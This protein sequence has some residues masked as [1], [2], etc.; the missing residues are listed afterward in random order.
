MAILVTAHGA[1]DI[2]KARDSNEDNLLVR[3]PDGLFVVADG[4]GGHANGE[5]ASQIAVS[6]IG[7]IGTSA[8]AIC[9]DYDQSAGYV[10]R[11][12]FL[13]AHARI[14]EGQL[15]GPQ[16]S[17]FRPSNDMGTT[18]VAALFMGSRMT[19]ANT[20]D[21]RA[22]LLRA[23]KLIQL[24]YDHSKLNRLLQ[25][26]SDLDAEGRAFLARQVAGVITEFLG[27]TRTPAVD[28]TAVDA[29]RGDRY[30][31][32]SDGLTDRIEDQR[33]ESALLDE[34]TP[35]M[36]CQ[37][38]I[39]MA[40]DAGGHDN[41]TVIVIDTDGDE[42]PEISPNDPEITYEQCKRLAETPQS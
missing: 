31:L 36:A 2:G 10:L 29:R 9:R 5:V 19:I 13:G 32:C 21:S 34:R 4:M 17:S 40:N 41:I 1:T 16:V 20:G 8:E 24:T 11:L 37:M 35:E 27:M 26:N 25:D 42:L 38:L 18:A 7:A 12:A 39:Q 22:Y 15:A 3:V 6:D 33:I 14:L 30:P 28:I 23:G